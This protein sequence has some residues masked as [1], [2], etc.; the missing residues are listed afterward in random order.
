LITIT[1]GGWGGGRGGGGGGGGGGGAKLSDGSVCHVY[2]GSRESV[3]ISFSSSF[4]KL[5]LNTLPS[6]S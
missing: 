6:I 4:T 2:E 5:Y 3:Q 1:E